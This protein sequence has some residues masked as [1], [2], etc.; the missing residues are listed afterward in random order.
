MPNSRNL[1]ENPPSHYQ[2]QRQPSNFP[3][4]VS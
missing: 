2:G 4:E 3:C 1:N